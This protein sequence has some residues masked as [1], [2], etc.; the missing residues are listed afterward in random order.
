VFSERISGARSDRPQLTKLM[1][2]LKTDDA[3]MVTKLDRL[4]RSA[5]ELLNLI[6]RIDKTGAGFRSL[7]DPLWDTTTPQGRFLRTIL[8]GVA[9]L[10]RDTIRERTDEGRKRR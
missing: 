7:G 1:A 6:D 8:A 2:A 5:R 10:E 3:I 4:G 9:E